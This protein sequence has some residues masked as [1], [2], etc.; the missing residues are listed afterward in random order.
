MTQ[1]LMKSKKPKMK[2]WRRKT[3]RK[4]Q[5]S[6]KEDHTEKHMPTGKQLRD[7]Y[8]IFVYSPLIYKHVDLIVVLQGFCKASFSVIFLWVLFN[9]F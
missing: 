8:V 5:D 6:A 1:Q 9:R 2:L 3:R 7:C 4:K